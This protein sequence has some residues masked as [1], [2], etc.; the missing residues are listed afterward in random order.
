VPDDLGELDAFYDVYPRIE[1]EFQAA[2]DQSL[3]PRGPEQLYDLVGE[4]GLAPTSRVLDLGCG[5]GG[6]TLTLAERFGCTVVGI[7]PV[8]RHL[9]LARAALGEATERSPDLGAR[10]SFE[11]G[12]AQAI[13]LPDASVDLVWC[14]DVLYHVAALET[15]YVECR[16]VIRPEGRALVYQWFATDRLETIEAAWLW[17]TMGIVPANADPSR[18]ERA[19][20]A[21]GLQ[22]DRRVDLGSE[23]GERLEE[24][25]GHATHRLLRAARLLRAP[26]RYIARFGQRAYDIMLG[27]CLWHIYRMIGKL[28][29][30]VYLLSADLQ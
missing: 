11:R 23:W 26:E 28:G 24:Q 17:K 4:L 8:E 10:V 18:T 19:I 27:D 30:R 29:P 13:P 25:S 15:A 21:A 9:E 14:R 12:A 1:A 22:V 6:H 16:R 2:L 20:V 5:Q 3:G 7:D